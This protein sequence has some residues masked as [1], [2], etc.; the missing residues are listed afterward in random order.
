MKSVYIETTIPSFY[1]E[2]RPTDP[3]KTWRA[4]TRKWW[5]EKRF[6]YALYSSRWVLAEL[7]LAPRG[8][9]H[10]CRNL[11][12]TVSILE[13]PR[14]FRSIVDY[15]IE[16]RLMPGEASNDAAHLAIASAYKMDFLL[17]WN[18]KHLANAH[19]MEHIGVLNK[20][21][22]LHTPIITTPLGLMESAEK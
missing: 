4:V 12:R 11:L 5:D 2:T 10:K 17:T 6:N 21:L 13:N 3:A 22:G 7:V 1:H 14:N 8:K 19:K 20:R 15:Y 9:A 18:C 16:H